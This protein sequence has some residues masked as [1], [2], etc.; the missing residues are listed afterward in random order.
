MQQR[1]PSL[2]VP[3]IAFAHR[4]AR[5]HAPENTLEAFR[6]ALRLGATGLES[7]VWLT[8]DGVAVLDHDGVVAGPR[9]GTSPIAWPPRPSSPAHIPTLAEL[10]DACGTDF[11]L[12]LDVK[13]PAAVDRGRSRRPRE[14]GRRRG[15]RLWL[16]HHDLAQRGAVARARP[17]TCS[18][19]TPPGCGRSRRAR[20]GAPRAGRRRHRR[21]QHAPHRLDR[22][23]DHAVPPLRSLRVR[24]GR[25]ARPR[26]RT[27]CSHGASTASTATTSTA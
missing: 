10:Y 6:L 24:L 19:S 20:S 25:A 8:A 18:W 12:S 4:G 27:R 14:R 7:D 11:E 13:D 17:A 22:R 21:H 23:A 15:Q 2:L 3:P 26:P 5:A 9:R 1:L 16:C